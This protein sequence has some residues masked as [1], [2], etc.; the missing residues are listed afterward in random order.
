[1]IDPSWCVRKTLLLRV[2]SPP[3]L[4]T[5]TRFYHEN[6]SECSLIVRER[7]SYPGWIWMPIQGFWCADLR[8]YYM[9]SHIDYYWCLFGESW[10]PVSEIPPKKMV[11]IW[12]NMRSSLWDSIK[13]DNHI[14][15]VFRFSSFLQF[16]VILRVLMWSHRL[17]LFETRLI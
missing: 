7:D 16:S 1:M 6:G 11:C 14:W 2:K 12:R 10:N 4:C 13:K 9:I 17:I 8:L 5:W 3:L 15:N